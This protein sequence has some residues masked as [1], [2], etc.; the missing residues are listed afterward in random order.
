MN[1]KET[2]FI[3]SLKGYSLSNED[4][5]FIL[6]PDTKINTIS[7]LDDVKHFDEL[8]DNLG[9]CIVLYGTESVNVGHWVALIKRG[10][11]IE[12]F[13]SYGNSPFDLAKGLGMD[14]D[15]DKLV[16][17]DGMKKMLKLIHD[18]GYDL[19]WND[20]KFQRKDSYIATCGRHAVF[21][22]ILY[23]LDLEQY[24]KYLK[25]MKTELKAD[26]DSLITAIT[27]PILHKNFLNNPNYQ[28]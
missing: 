13:D 26:Y 24:Q 8:L 18:A 27:H 21:R 17:K 16:N 5:D 14:K 19:K 20:V 28:K 1:K 25:D 6:N 23:K 10:N 7:K 22:L 2:K 11:T 4:L 9:R 3:N 12:F 15:N